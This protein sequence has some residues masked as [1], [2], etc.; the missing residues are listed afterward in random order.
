MLVFLQ[1]GMDGCSYSARALAVDN[2]NGIK[3]REIGAVEIAL[4]NAYRFVGHHTAQVYLGLD[5]YVAQLGL[6]L[7]HILLLFA[8]Y[9]VQQANFVLADG[10]LHDACL[11]GEHTVGTYGDYLSAGTELHMTIERLVPDEGGALVVFSSQSVTMTLA[12]SG[13]GGGRGREGEH[14]V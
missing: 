11:Q 9:S 7:F 1:R 14:E 12:L 8:L 6:Y 13:E 3:V 5:A 4:H 2:G 10:Y